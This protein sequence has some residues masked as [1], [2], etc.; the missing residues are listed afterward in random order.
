MQAIRPQQASSPPA[1]EKCPVV[2]GVWRF[3]SD[4]SCVSPGAHFPRRC[5]PPSCPP[6]TQKKS[7]HAPRPPIPGYCRGEV[8]G[9]FGSERCSEQRVS[10]GDK[11]HREK[12]GLV[13][14]GG[15][16]FPPE[17]GH[18]EAQVLVHRQ[19]TRMLGV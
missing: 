4:P 6:S 10:G 5:P 15:D 2:S 9:G 19:R 18:E 1:T 13:R 3:T 11:G 17:S 16:F 8:G 14:S 7:H 12:D